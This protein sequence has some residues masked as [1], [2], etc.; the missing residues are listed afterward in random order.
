MF[1]ANFRTS[2]LFLTG[3]SLVFVSAKAEAQGGAF[4]PGTDY[5]ALRP[6]SGSRNFNRASGDFNDD[7]VRDLLTED[8]GY[9]EVISGRDGNVLFSAGWGSSSAGS[10]VQ[11]GAA[12]DLRWIGDFNG[13]APSDVVFLWAPNPALQAV[14]LGYPQIVLGNDLGGIAFQSHALPAA[15]AFGAGDQDGDGLDDVTFGGNPNGQGEFD[16]HGVHGLIRRLNELVH[17]QVHPISDLT[18]DGN[19]DLFAYR[20][21]SSSFPVWME[22]LT[23]N[24]LQFLPK[25]S[26]GIARTGAVLGDVNGDGFVD[27]AVAFSAGLFQ[28]EDE[29]WIYSGMDG[30]TLRTHSEPGLEELSSGIAPAGDVDLDGLADY[31]IQFSRGS[32]STE[33][34]HSGADGSVLFERQTADS[35][36]DDPIMD[37]GRT[38]YR[39]RRVG[40]LGPDP[41]DRPGS[42]LAIRDQY[43]EILPGLG[44]DQTQL[45]S[46]AGGSAQ[47]TL[48]M[49]P[50]EADFLYAILASNLKPGSSFLGYVEVPL[51]QGPLFQI[52]LHNP[53]SFFHGAQG[54]L[55]AEA[56][57]EAVLDLP[58][59]LITP[60]AGTTVRFAAVTFEPQSFQ[61]SFSSRAVAVEI[62]P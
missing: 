10:S 52:M 31:A 40:W 18:G 57:G 41:F 14:S 13:D 27:C 46:G 22:S 56:E 50:S 1:K 36:L 59:N 7:G 39:H 55:D 26:G 25:P 51:A 42:L 9:V 19:V 5:P 24:L 16:T 54:Q 32:Q 38:P 60:W 61:A 33:R 23:G 29:F 3:L 62:L 53:P 49:P 45:S 12:W 15:Y 6:W 58:P 20:P 8:D 37:F 47:F 30:S 48:H 34:I 35:G 43:L 11:S 21:G 2:L 17:D 28:Y 4:V 44:S